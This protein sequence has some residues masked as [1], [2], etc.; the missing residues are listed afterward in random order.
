[1]TNKNNI[2]TLCIMNKWKL[3]G[4]YIRKPI[5]YFDIDKDGFEIVKYKWVYKFSNY[6][7]ETKDNKYID[8]IMIYDRN[9]Y[10][11]IMTE[12]DINLQGMVI[13]ND[14]YK[15]YYDYVI[16][17]ET[18]NLLYYSLSRDEFIDSYYE[19][20]EF[21]IKNFKHIKP[22]DYYLDL[23]DNFEC[24]DLFYFN[25]DEHKK[26]RDLVTH[27]F[28][29]YNNLP[30][31]Y[32]CVHSIKISKSGEV[33]PC[34]EILYVGNKVPKVNPM[35]YFK[36]I[37]IIYEHKNSPENVLINDCVLHYHNII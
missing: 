21:M 10:I 8:G 14:I 26:A 1:M 29:S 19:V 13:E 20:S 2:F 31:F 16:S 37:P 22:L 5:Q 27:I 23:Y 4:L 34:V 30:W 17:N 35:M 25:D 15:K 7:C 36:E 12:V 32:D 33:Y 6:F 11:N 18:N 3:R 9:K 24:D 28:N